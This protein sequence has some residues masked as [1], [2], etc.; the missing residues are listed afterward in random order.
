VRDRIGRTRRAIYF[1]YNCLEGVPLQSQAIVEVPFDTF[2]MGAKENKPLTKRSRLLTE[3]RRR[4]ILELVNREGRAMI[5]D[6]SKRFGVSAVT[7]RGDV[8]SLCKRNLLIRSHG[9]AIPLDRVVMDSPLEVKATRHHNEKA[10][11]GKCAAALVEPGQTVL[12]DSGTT[13]LEVARALIQ[14]VPRGITVVTNSLAVASELTL[15]SEINVIMIGG[16]L[17]HISQSFV[18]PQ[19]QKTLSEL[20]VDRFFLGVDGLDPGVGTFTP[21]VL[22]A[23]LNATMIRVARR[24]TVVTDS[25]KIGRRSLTLIAPIDSIHQLVTDS[26]IRAEDRLA[27]ESRGIEVLVA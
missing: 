7:V 9:G 26:S 24:T 1:D 5:S 27:L 22:E 25:S 16:L 6:L 20:H 8:D 12:L 3:E 19:A 4:S 23:E 21:D 10:R 18:G 13:T 17:R 2:T 14:N 15:A 11:I